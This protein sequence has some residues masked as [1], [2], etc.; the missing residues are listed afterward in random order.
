MFTILK[1][2]AGVWWHIFN[3][4]AT[5]VHLSDFDV[6]IEAVSNSFVIEAKNGSNIPSQAT[7]ISNI[8]VINEIISSSP[9]PFTG[10]DG[11]IAL[12]TSLSYPPY[13]S[14][15]PLQPPVRIW[16]KGQGSYFR[17]PQEWI[18]ANFDDSGLGINE[19]IGWE[20]DTDLEGKTLIGQTDGGL[21][22]TIGNSYGFAHTVLVAHEHDSIEYS[23]GRKGVNTVGK[24]ATVAGW[25]LDGSSATDKTNKTSKNGQTQTGAP[26]TVETGANKNYQPSL[27]VLFVKRTEDLWAN[28]VGGGG[29]SKT[30]SNLYNQYNGTSV[31]VPSGFTLTR[32]V[33]LN[34]INTAFTGIVTGTDLVI[35]DGVFR[36]IYLIDGYTI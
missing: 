15:A 20:K 11:L 36:D 9:I 35:T 31:T 13:L 33:S 30:P 25:E 12:L 5:K 23:D 10:A 3:N 14:N 7:S 8:Q 26:S 22:D 6:T 19:A 16:I 2:L 4:E 32:I 21:F 34:D 28:S 18:D 24:G 27:I 1:D 17:R 29:G